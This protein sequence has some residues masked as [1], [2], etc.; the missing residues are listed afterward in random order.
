MSALEP[1]LESFLWRGCSLIFHCHSGF[2]QP[3]ITPS[4]PDR[5]PQD[6]LAECSGKHQ[7]TSSKNTLFYSS[8]KVFFLKKGEFYLIY[9]LAYAH[10]SFKLHAN[11][12]INHW[13]MNKWNQTCNNG[14]IFSAPSPAQSAAG[15]SRRSNRAEIVLSCSYKINRR[16]ERLFSIC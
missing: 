2:P 1:S 15:P 9:S 4:A 12:T 11:N 5:I 13:Y 6:Q 10:L 3:G 8:L 16:N 14:L 7:T